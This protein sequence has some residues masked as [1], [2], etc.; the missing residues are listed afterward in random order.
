MPTPFLSLTWTDHVTG[1]Q[2]YR[3]SWSWTAWYG[4]WRAADYGCAP[5]AHSTRWRAWPVA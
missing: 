4:E 5:A 1:R 3:A 2:G